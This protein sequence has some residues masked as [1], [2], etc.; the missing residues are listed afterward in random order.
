MKKLPQT[1]LQEHKHGYMNELYRAI[2]DSIPM[3]I[4]VFVMM[5]NFDDIFDLSVYTP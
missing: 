3:I 1:W 5:S 4:I 2:K